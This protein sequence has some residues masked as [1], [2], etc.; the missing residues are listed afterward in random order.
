MLYEEVNGDIDIR[1]PWMR[2]SME[3]INHTENM[4][5]VGA[6]SI[7]NEIL[8]DGQNYLHDKDSQEKLVLSFC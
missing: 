4:C 1:L 2:K 5:I 6:S 3:R 8:F 7:V